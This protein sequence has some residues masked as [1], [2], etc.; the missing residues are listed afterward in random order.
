MKKACD[1]LC[2]SLKKRADLTGSKKPV[3]VRVFEWKI[4][5][6]LQNLTSNFEKAILEF[7]PAEKFD[8]LAILK[9]FSHS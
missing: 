9:F 2:E 4:I 7:Y 6:Q 5:P 1:R 8:I 3:A